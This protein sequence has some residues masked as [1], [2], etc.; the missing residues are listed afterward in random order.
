M[1]NN[2]NC[3]YIIPRIPFPPVGGDRL[4]Y[5]SSIKLLA[6]SFSL[7][8]IIISD[9]PLD[10]NAKKF[11]ET[12]TA[13][14]KVF[15]YPKLRF[16]INTLKGFFN[17]NPLQV[18]YYYFKSVKAYCEAKIN[19]DDIVICNLIRTALYAEN[20]SNV[21]ILNVEDYIYLNYKSSLKKVSSFFW[22]IIYKIELPKLQRFEQRCVAKFNCSTFVNEAEQLFYAGKGNTAWVPNGVSDELCAREFSEAEPKQKEVVYFGK[23][24][25]QPNID[26]VTW[27]VNNVIT[28]YTDIKLIILGAQP[29][30]KIEALK[31]KYPGNVEIIGYVDDP[32]KIMKS[33]V[34]VIAPMQTGAGLQN[35][36]LEAMA[37][38]CVV[39]AS[40]LGA[41]PVKGAQHGKHLFK[42]D[43]PGEYAAMIDT[44][45]NNLEHS[46]AIQISARQFIKENY[47]WHIYKE[48]FFKIVS[49]LTGN[50][51]L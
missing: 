17:S 3:F 6:N 15:H 9:T 16:Y 13:S 27:F 7:H 44:L 21:K 24:D 32:F 10:D 43:T 22:K 1:A 39:L 42:C 23:M 49:T 31:N 34:A 11:L 5:F 19:A 12:H 33:A 51:L 20:L 28:K 14:Y 18:N 4:K 36:I 48:R 35:K 50:R 41:N 29:G 46:K 40:S 37:I 8:V 45:F 30:K 47:T 2:P 38:G 26:A 25:Y